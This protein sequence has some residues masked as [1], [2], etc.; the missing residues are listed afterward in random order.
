[1]QWRRV[2]LQ[3]ERWVWHSHPL[4]VRLKLAQPSCRLC[5]SGALL[6]SLQCHL[7]AAGTEATLLNG[8]WLQQR[9]PPLAWRGSVEGGCGLECCPP[10]LG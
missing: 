7:A 8:D 2:R 10:R 6:H 5:G 3:L 9:T 4:G 1:M